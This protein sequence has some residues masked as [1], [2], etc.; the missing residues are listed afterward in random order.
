[1]RRREML[2]KCIEMIKE[3]DEKELLIMF[4]TTSLKMILDGLKHSINIQETANMITNAITAC[5]MNYNGKEKHVDK[6]G[7]DISYEGT[8]EY[9]QGYHKGNIEAYQNILEYIYDVFELE[10]ERKFYEDIISRAIEKKE[11]DIEEKKTL[12]LE[13]DNKNINYQIT[14]NYKGMVKNGTN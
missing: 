9:A 14:K 4:D 13:I 1:M 7:K 3:F 12:I 10:E 5:K 2:E 11:S 6:N 8:K